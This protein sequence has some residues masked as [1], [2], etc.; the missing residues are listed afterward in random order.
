M[1]YEVHTGEQAFDAIRQA[2]RYIAVDCQSPLNAKRWLERLWDK[3]DDLE[4]MPRRFAVDEVYTRRVDHP[5]HKMVFGRYLV[6][7]QVD[8][9]GQRVD[10]VDFVAG[11]RRTEA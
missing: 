8:E 1:R 4:E 9:Q 7:Y 6:F 2:A 3:I 11:A 5:T 10:I